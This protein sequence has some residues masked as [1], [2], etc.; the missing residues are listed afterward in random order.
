MVNGNCFGN[1]ALQS[2]GGDRQVL[3]LVA[4]ERQ[5]FVADENAQGEV[6]LMQPNQLGDAVQFGRE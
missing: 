5:P 2:G 1:Q 4:L 6:I 3:S